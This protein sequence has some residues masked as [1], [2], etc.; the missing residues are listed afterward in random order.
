MN[1]RATRADNSG[2][3][4]ALPVRRGRR[5]RA[6]WRAGSSSSRSRRRTV[7][8]FLPEAHVTRLQAATPGGRPGL[9]CADARSGP[10]AAGASTWSRSRSTATA[11][12]TA[13]RISAMPTSEA[14]AAGERLQKVLA[15]AG[16]GSRRAG[17]ELIRAGRVRVNGGVV[18][19]L[20]SRVDPAPRSRSRWM[21]ASSQLAAARLPLRAAEQASRAWSRPPTTRR[22]VQPCSTWSKP[23]YRLFPVG[24]L[25]LDSEGL[26]LLTDD[27]QL[28]YR[29]THARYEVEKQYH[30][31]VTCRDLDHRRLDEL[32]R[33]VDARRR[34]GPRRRGAHRPHDARPV[35][36]S[37]SC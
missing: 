1:W 12:C 23:R 11:A 15:G 7:G 34:P 21:G 16:V 5:A 14:T 27:G 25:D 26:V 30:A 18:E 29:L 2:A 4:L 19:Q 22:V 8:K 20:G 13:T 24:R 35:P 31:Q 17:E 6:R 32:R 3:Q 28:T 9:L 33:G 10:S 36:G 37:A